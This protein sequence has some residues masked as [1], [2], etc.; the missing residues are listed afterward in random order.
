MKANFRASI[1]TQRPEVFQ[2]ED[3]TLVITTNDDLSTATEIEF[4]ID[5]PTMIKKT[6]SAAEIS[7]VTATQFSVALVPGDTEN[8]PDGKYRF[9]CRA[10][11]GGLKKNGVFNP[12]RIR[13]MRSLMVV[14]TGSQGDYDQRDC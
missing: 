6:L 11:V 3:K 5:T 12:N 8:V 13:V 10:T 2:G 7:G 14:N 1:T 9:Q 4:N